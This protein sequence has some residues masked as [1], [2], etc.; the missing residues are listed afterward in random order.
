MIHSLYVS[1]GGICLYSHNFK[2]DATVDDQLL[3]G[4]LTGRNYIRRSF[5]IMQN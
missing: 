1:D 4:F 5:L 3:L 2:E